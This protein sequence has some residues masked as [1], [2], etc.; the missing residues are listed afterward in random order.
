MKIGIVQFAPEWENPEKSILIV[1]KLLSQKNS[2][3]D[4]LI[5]PEMSLTGFSVN[6]RN[7][8]E[9]L[10]GTSTTF[11][12]NL[13]AKLKKHIFAGIIEKDNDNVYNSLVHFDP[14]GLIM[15]RYRKIHPFSFAKEEKY[16]DSAKEPVI[17]KIDG[18]KIGLSVCYDLRFPELYRK[19][20]KE[21]ADILINIANWPV[22]RI[23][24]WKILLRARSV[25]NI[26]YTIGVN[27]TGN[28]PFNKYNG[29]SAIFDP[30]GNELLMTDEKE[31]IFEIDIDM[32]K[33]KSQREKFPFLNDI[34][35]I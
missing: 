1:E 12:I 22:Q 32:D 31:E 17:T 33:V 18:N 27:R 15:A 4:V 14:N 7:I 19:Y 26:A 23:E 24:H 25:E 5:F 8:A 21:R 6:S 28:D 29:C 3:A 10:D 13:A 11:F 20:A 2:E 16:F 34:K 30:A 9:E 35:L